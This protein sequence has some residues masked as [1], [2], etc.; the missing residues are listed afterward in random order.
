M[1][2]TSLGIVLSRSVRLRIGRLFAF[3]GVFVALLSNASAQLAISTHA[4]SAGLTG[5]TDGT[6][7]AARFSNPSGVAV[8]IAGNA[9]IADAVNNR[10]RKVTPGGVVTTVAGSGTAGSNDATGTSA[11]FSSPQ[12][13]A[14]DSTATN[15]Y[16][17]DTGSHKIRKIVISSGAVTTIAGTGGT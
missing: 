16:V 2:I 17:A 13:I 12:G 14:I 4:G 15:L 7:N 10:I 6:G 5:T 3:T 9:Y 8:D 1:K 11:T